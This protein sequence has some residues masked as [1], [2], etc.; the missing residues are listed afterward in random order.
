MTKPKTYQG[1]LEHLPA[2]LLPLTRDERWLIW[3]WELRITKAGKQKWTKPPRQARDPGKLT[4]LRGWHLAK[5][6]LPNVAPFGGFEV[7]SRRIREA[8]IWLGATDPCETM[9]KVR[10]DDPVREALEAVMA[11]WKQHLGLSA[12]HS[13]QTVIARATVEAD[14]HAALLN[15]AASKNNGGTISN[16]RLGRWLKQVEGRIVDRLTLKREGITRGYPLWQLTKT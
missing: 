3:N 8:L 16:E 7:W 10:S 1:D 14:F 12:G 13:V 2:A 15:V 11:Q 6:Q 4:V 5:A 9:A